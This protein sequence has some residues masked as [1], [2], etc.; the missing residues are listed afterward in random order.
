MIKNQKEK[1]G[2]EFLFIGANIDAA[3]A[4]DY[5]ADRKRTAVLCDTVA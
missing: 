2:W 4:V 1:Y 5:H 3:R